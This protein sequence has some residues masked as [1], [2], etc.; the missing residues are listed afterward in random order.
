MKKTQSFE[1][2]VCGKLFK[3][4]LDALSCE[5]IHAKQE[6]DK[7]EI[8]EKKEKLLALSRTFYNHLDDVTAS[9]F[10]NALEKAYSEFGINLT[11]ELSGL[12]VIIK[13]NEYIN[14]LATV[15]G[16][17]SYFE[18]IDEN[19]LK[20]IDELTSINQNIVSSYYLTKILKRDPYIF[21][22]LATFFGFRNIGGSSYQTMKNATSFQY[23][24]EYYIKYQDMAK[25]GDIF[26][27]I[28]CNR[29]FVKITKEEEGLL[30]IYNRELSA[31]EVLN[32]YNATKSR[33][34]Y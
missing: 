16:S 21:S 6:L 17:T 34:G 31:D 5:E 19:F 14:I 11:L 10:K 25:F 3:Q 8:E 2:E 29:R 1:C 28:D 7:K 24:I 15:S 12:T 32:K 9:S 27:Y 18:N 13:E 22:D 20:D 30:K 26:K 23:G 33:F 4:K